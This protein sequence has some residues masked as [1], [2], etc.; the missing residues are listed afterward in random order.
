MRLILKVKSLLTMLSAVDAVARQRTGTRDRSRAV[1]PSRRSC[2]LTGHPAG[3]RYLS[4]QVSWLTGRRL[5]LGL[6]GANASDTRWTLDS[7]LTV[8][9]AAPV[10]HRLP[11]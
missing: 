8:A 3:G 5:G 2:G 10:S 11:S 7:P 1:V 9:G 4:G 6:P